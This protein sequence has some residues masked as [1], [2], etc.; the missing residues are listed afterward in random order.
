MNVNKIV[1]SKLKKVEFPPPLGTDF[2][3]RTTPPSHLI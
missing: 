2:G 3:Y 1:V